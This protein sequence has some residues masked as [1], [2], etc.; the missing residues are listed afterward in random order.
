M[1]LKFVHMTFITIWIKLIAPAM[2]YQLMD[3]SVYLSD[4][5]FE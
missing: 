2:L 5:V 3:Y 1:S 4:F